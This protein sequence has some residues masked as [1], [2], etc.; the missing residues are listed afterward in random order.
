[1]YLILSKD[2]NNLANRINQTIQD[3]DPKKRNIKIVKITPSDKI[4]KL[5]VL[6]RLYTNLFDLNTPLK[7]TFKGFELI[8]NPTLYKEQLKDPNLSLLESTAKDIIQDITS[9]FYTP[10]TLVTLVIG[11]VAT[12]GVIYLLYKTYKG[13]DVELWKKIT[14]VLLVLTSLVIIFQLLKY[15]PLHSETV[16]RSA[17][18]TGLVSVS[19][20]NLITENYSFLRLLESEENKTVIKKIVNT[21]FESPQKAM[22]QTISLVKQVV[23]SNSETYK[24]YLD[25]LKH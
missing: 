17:V 9:L 3:I 7:D 20:D 25:L 24:N 19:S 13:E 6:S 4:T 8:Y 5:I 14:V 23:P 21:L 10:K 22:L 12:S 18:K 16:E 11:S 15:P 2:I 1:M